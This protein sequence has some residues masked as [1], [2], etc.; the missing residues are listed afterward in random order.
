MRQCPFFIMGYRFS[1]VMEKTD[2]LGQEIQSLD[3]LRTKK[4]QIAYTNSSPAAISAV[5]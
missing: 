3:L 5:Q 2:E 1:I 4:I